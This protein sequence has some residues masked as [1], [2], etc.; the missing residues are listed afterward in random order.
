MIPPTLPFHGVLG[1]Q[2]SSP[3]AA[4]SQTGSLGNRE[5]WYSVEDK[6]RRDVTNMVLTGMSR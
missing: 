4:S 2:T 5:L 1:I 3:L 6:N